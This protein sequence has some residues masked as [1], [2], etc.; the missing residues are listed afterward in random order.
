VNAPASAAWRAQLT[1]DG[2]WTLLHPLHG[3]S[4]HSQAGAWTQARERYAS[5]I[6]DLPPEIVATGVVRLLDIGTGTGLNLAAAIE[7]C[8]E[9]GLALDAL[10]LEL[11]ESPL[12]ATLA[13]WRE[14]GSHRTVHGRVL[15][16]IEAA[17]SPAAAKAAS[18]R[19]ALPGPGAHHLE[20]LLGDARRSLPEI[21]GER[22]F[23]AVFLDPFS[24][25][26]DPPLWE[27]PFMH[28]VARRMA[29]GARLAT[30]TTSL[31][32][33]ASLARAGLA[34]G[35][36]PRVGRKAAG[37]LASRGGSVPALDPRT[38]RKLATRARVG[39]K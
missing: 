18:A 1:D 37:T 13:L 23:D 26:V 14:S 9:R 6:A 19:R 4:C 3:E 30:Y 29:A 21:D 12:R 34:V 36:G 15:E 25:R 10:T 16:W 38:K 20:L 28:E 5:V 39:E 35:A 2:S 8:D 17:L 31:R 27:E 24:P 22:R 33:R 7:A 32:V 11:E